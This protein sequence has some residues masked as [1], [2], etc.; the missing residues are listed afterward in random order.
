MRERVLDVVLQ[1]LGVAKLAIALGT[2][3][4]FARGRRQRGHCCSC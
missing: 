3:D 4:G 2:I 1:V